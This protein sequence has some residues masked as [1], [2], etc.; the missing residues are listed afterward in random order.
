MFTIKTQEPN[1]PIVVIVTKSTEEFL[2]IYLNKISY[3]FSERV[4]D[5]TS[6]E[7]D[8]T[9][10]WNDNKD[11][12]TQEPAEDVMD[13]LKMLFAKRQPDNYVITDFDIIELDETFQ[14]KPE[15]RVITYFF[16]FEPETGFPIHRAYELPISPEWIDE[17]FSKHFPSLPEAERVTMLEDTRFD[18]NDSV[19]KKAIIDYIK[20]SELIAL[21]KKECETLIKDFEKYFGLKPGQPIEFDKLNSAEFPLC[22]EE[23]ILHLG[24]DAKEAM[25]YAIN[26]EAKIYHQ[27]PTKDWEAHLEAKA[28]ELLDFYQANRS[29]IYDELDKQHPCKYI[30]SLEDTKSEVLYGYIGLAADESSNRIN[31]T[32]L[33]T[34]LECLS[35]KCGYPQEV[36]SDYLCYEESDYFTEK[37]L[38][39]V[40]KLLS[41]YYK[42]LPLNLEATSLVVPIK[43][44]VNNYINYLCTKERYTHLK[45]TRMATAMEIEYPENAYIGFKKQEDLI[46]PTFLTEFNFKLPTEIKYTYKRPKDIPSPVFSVSPEM[47]ERIKEKAVPFTFGLG[48][49]ARKPDHVKDE[50]Y[51]R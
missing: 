33:I 23:A 48:G 6:D 7:P 1:G 36:I 43:T 11:R 15:L 40:D 26:E 27:L 38:K 46:S 18:D 45:S 12:L 32:D 30:K 9:A 17:T 29:Y 20:N 14:E 3:S 51:S 49:D 22:L 24:K 5:I 25:V 34:Q 19:L 21:H 37:E 13:G 2:A 50:Y 44:D 35:L 4:T 31:K 42:V 8:I 10:W 39:N 47:Y 41:A 16:T 28:P